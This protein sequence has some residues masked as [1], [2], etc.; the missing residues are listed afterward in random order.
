MWTV[1]PKTSLN[2]SYLSMREQTSL[3][4]LRENLIKKSRADFK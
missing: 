3:T 4:K 1:F 2:L